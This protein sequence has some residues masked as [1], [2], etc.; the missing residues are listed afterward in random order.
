MNNESQGA[1]I[2]ANADFF[3]KICQQETFAV[4]RIFGVCK[5][6][7]KQLGVYSVSRAPALQ[8]Y[9]EIVV[10]YGPQKSSPGYA[11]AEGGR[12][13]A[14]RTVTYT[15]GRGSSVS[16]KKWFEGNTK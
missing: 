1:T 2:T 14:V 7:D 11:V 5:R 15:P 16:I 13:P 3:N 4:Y 12:P 9:I 8:E 6:W 10:V